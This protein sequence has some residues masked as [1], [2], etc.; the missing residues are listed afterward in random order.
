MYSCK[1]K[2]CKFFIRHNITWH[3]MFVRHLYLGIRQMI[4]LQQFCIMPIQESNTQGNELSEGIWWLSEQTDKFNK[5]KNKQM[6]ETEI[7]SETETDWNL[8][9]NLYFKV[10]TFI[11]QTILWKKNENT[12]K[13]IVPPLSVSDSVYIRILKAY[14]FLRPLPSAAE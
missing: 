6:T 8:P 3:L 11:W 7:W 9:N 5:W 1:Y 13:I 10:A 14:W 4:I 2:S 12:W